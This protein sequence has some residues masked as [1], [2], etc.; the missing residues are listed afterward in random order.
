MRYP[1]TGWTQT[2]KD[3]TSMMGLNNPDEV[4]REAE[5]RDQEIERKEQLT[6]EGEPEELDRQPEATDDEDAEDNDG[7]PPVASRG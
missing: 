4:V 5:Q 6:Q 3:V 7:G 1:T 2:Q